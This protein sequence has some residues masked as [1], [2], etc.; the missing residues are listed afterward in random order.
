MVKQNISE[1][2][3]MTDEDLEMLAWVVET[4]LRHNAR[5]IKSKKP[6]TMHVAVPFEKG[7]YKLDSSGWS[8]LVVGFIPKDFVEKFKMAVTYDDSSHKLTFNFRGGTK[9]GRKSFLTKR[10]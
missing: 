9:H 2:R 1:I 10:I 3:R 6:F 5:K 8:S 7:E 4:S